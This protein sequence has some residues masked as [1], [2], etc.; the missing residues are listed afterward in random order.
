MSNMEMNEK[1]EI[2]KRII[3]ALHKGKDVET[4]KEEFKDV[5]SRIS[6]LEIPIIEQELI[7]EGM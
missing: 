2:V 5:L 3:K 7:K 4:L 6:P 1:V